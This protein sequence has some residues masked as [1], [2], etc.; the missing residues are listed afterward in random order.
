[1][2]LA[3][4]PGSY[5]PPEDNRGIQKDCEEDLQGARQSKG[6]NLRSEKWVS[7]AQ[8]RRSL[9]KYDVEIKSVDGKNKVVIPD[10]VL[11]DV[12]PLWEDF[13]VGKFLDI[14]P[15]LAKFHMV[16]NKIWS[17]GDDTAKVEVYDVNATT[18]RFKIKNSRFREKVIKR[19]MWNIAGVPMIAK[20]WTP[21]TE[22]EKQE[23]EAIPMWVHLRK[24]PLHMF[25][26]EALSFMTSTVG[27]PVH[28]HLETLACSNF[29][30]A[31]VFVNVDVSK[32]LPKEIKFVIEGK[33]FTAEFYYPWLPSRCSLCEKWGHTEK[34][35]VMK[36][37]EKK[38][39]DL[40]AKGE[41]AL[42]STDRVVAQMD[43]DVVSESVGLKKVHELPS[44]ASEVRASVS[45]EGGEEDWSTVSPDK[46]GRSQLKTPHREEV[47]VQISASKYSVLCLDEVEEGE[48]LVDNPLEEE[49]VNNEY[50]EV[51]DIREGDLLE[52]EILDQKVKDKEKAVEQKG[53][54]GKRVQKATAQDANSKGK[55][56]SRCKL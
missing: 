53:G 31:K 52:D 24:V 10:D 14:A 21:K 5:A 26:W 29:E 50:E 48:V 51:S 11:S 42:K 35:C 47:V 8:E 27:F 7:V 37:R 6:V 17:Y 22:E 54:G 1:M 3:A 20:K 55:R 46:V 12:T 56:S 40:S 36:K 4:S 28:L 34:V 49:E 15:H 23:E 32:T 2:V 38:Q 39:G 41:S 33:E 18:M 19:G 16:V 45:K 30:E 44:I 25:S 9:K 43:M 13:V